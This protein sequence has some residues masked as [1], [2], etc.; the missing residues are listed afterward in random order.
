MNQV[1]PLGLG[2]Q[3][4]FV[5]SA[6]TALENFRQLLETRKCPDQFVGKIPDLCHGKPFP[7]RLPVNERPKNDHCVIL[8]LESPHSDEYVSKR[9][10]PAVPCPAN[11]TTGQNICSYLGGLQEPHHL[12]SGLI[13][14]NAVQFQCSL[15]V[16]TDVFRDD[17]FR[18]VWNGSG[19]SDFIGRLRN[20]YL[21]GDMILNCCTKG[22]ADHDGL[23]LRDLVDVAIAEA[24]PTA[25]VTRLSHPSYWLGKIG[26]E[27]PV[28]RR[29]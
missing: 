26:R 16:G 19:R 22:G 27:R 29:R 1:T 11:G 13:L 7:V 6:D 3:A 21:D 18:G 14:M 24:T 25:P 4:D 20:C 23:F 10:G 17:V 28:K 15:G 12:T 9:G 5:A 8:V 2:V